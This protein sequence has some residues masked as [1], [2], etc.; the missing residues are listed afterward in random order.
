MVV[1]KNLPPE[2]FQTH[3]NLIPYVLATEK[4]T[5]RCP[6]DPCN[7]LCPCQLSTTGLQV[8]AEPITPSAAAAAAAALLDSAEARKTLQE[9]EVRRTPSKYLFV[10]HLA[11]Y[12]LFCYLFTPVVCSTKRKFALPQGGGDRQAG[13][14]PTAPRQPP[15]S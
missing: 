10:I 12:S 4:T 3:R 15:L 5:V 7:F 8:G 2:L 11:F 6:C 13:N 14:Q 1:Q 9:K